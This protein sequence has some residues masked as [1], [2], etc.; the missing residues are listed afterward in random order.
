MEKKELTVAKGKVL[1]GIVVSD[2]MDKTITVL[3]KVKSS[4]QLYKKASVNSK[5][6]KAHDVDNTAKAGDRVRIISGRPYSKQK[7]FRL[8]EIVK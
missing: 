3:V 7:S 8:L 6:Y 2:K 4:H 1:E 5:K